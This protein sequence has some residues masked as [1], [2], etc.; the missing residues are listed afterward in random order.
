MKT[1][2]LQYLCCPIC[3]NELTCIEHNPTAEIKQGILVC[4]E[5][6]RWYPVLDFI[7]ELL[8]DN[9]RDW[10][11]EIAFL[12][13]FSDQIPDDKIKKLSEKSLQLQKTS[14]QSPSEGQLYKKA[15]MSIEESVEDPD[16]FGPGLYSPFNK[17]RP[18]YTVELIRR[19]S[20][21][22][23][24]MG[25]KRKDVV[26]DIGSGY[27]WTTEW[28][29]KAGYE[30]IGVDICRTYFEVGK[31]R[32]GDSCPNLVIADV[33][34]LPIRDSVLNGILCFDAFHHIENRE[35]A[36]SL[37]CRTLRKGCSVILAEPGKDHGSLE[38]S[39]EV[40][41]K[42]GILEKGMD[43]SDVRSYIKDEDF[44]LPEQHYVLK[45][46]KDEL[47][48]YL[49]LCFVRSHSYVDCLIFSV[50][51]RGT[52]EYFSTSPNICRVEITPGF[53]PPVILNGRKKNVLSFQVKNTGD[54]IWKHQ[55]Q[56]AEG[57]VKLGGIVF[58]VE[59]NPLTETP[60]TRLSKDVYPGETVKLDL[61]L[62]EMKEPGSYFLQVDLE[63]KGFG[64][65][66]LQHGEKHRFNIIFQH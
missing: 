12:E 66:H 9:L 27:S 62:P 53:P 38:E 4:G 34:N 24:L 49:D 22:L 29:Q 15:E 43:L 5:C 21:L 56:N 50:K 18:E 39:I 59:G 19:F 11:R 1:S 13:V 45:L 28:L 63:N 54:T 20:L 7:P 60:I 14:A 40:M 55:G 17:H 8:P 42:Y 44:L 61:V 46:K 47:K 51:K 3:R 23:P 26:L 41:E 2:L 6:G 48:S 10:D 32:M 52:R 25:L 58:D 36:F 33:E 37:F 35:K 31:K 64:W 16:F 57:E 65:F 30:S